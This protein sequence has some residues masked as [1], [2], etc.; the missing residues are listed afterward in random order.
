MRK[1]Y[2]AA[3]LFLSLLATAQEKRIVLHQINIVD[4]EI[5]TIQPAQSVVIT[6]DRIT[7]IG[8]AASFKAAAGDSLVDCKGQYLIPGLWDMHTH[9]WAPDYFFSLFIANGITGIRGMFEQA[10]TADK[11]RT[12]GLTPGELVPRG[13]YAGPIVDGPKPIWPGSVGV[14]DAA[15]GRRVVDSLK[16]TLKVD[17]IKVYSLLEPDVFAAI[18]DE[19]KKQNI[20]FA[21]HVPNKVRLLDAAK[22]GQK[23]TEHLYGF[24]EMASDSSDY[25]YSLVTGTIKDTVRYPNSLARRAMLQR[26]F[27]EKKLTDGIK[28]LKQYDSYVC[29]TMTV[30]R[31]IAYINDTSFT[32]DPRKVYL[33]PMM[34]NMWDPKNDFRL[35]TAGPEFFQS[36]QADYALK[37]KVVTALHKA[38]IPILAG[39]DTPNPYCFPGFSLHDEL[40]IFTECG[41]SPA[42]AL[43]TATLNPARYFGIEKETGSV[44]TGKAADLVIL[45]ANPL[46][47]ISNT[48]Q[49]SAVVLKGK[50][51]GPETV[52]GLLQKARKI[53]GN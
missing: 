11:W 52:S 53:A 45:K 36:Q 1:I 16:N 26:T 51:L 35:R 29:P 6:G 4:V 21:G 47:Q 42:E 25:Y 50:F 48:R 23:S 28:A 7:A 5:G 10:F 27:N 49:I 3:I 37:K 34:K 8:K 31:G 33:V 44:A 2:F 17:F 9:V 46:E 39:T 12:Q 19:A 15:R 30:N 18:A 40:V 13:Y 20:V 14:G 38:G 22:A 41:L 24:L 32:N 43:R